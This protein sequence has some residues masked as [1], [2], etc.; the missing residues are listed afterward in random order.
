MPR[1]GKRR[2]GHMLTPRLATCQLQ[3]SI[4]R[5]SLECW[6][7]SWSKKPETASRVRGRIEAVLDF[8]AVRGYRVGQKSGPVEGASQRG[9]SGP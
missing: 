7:R 6:I 4:R 1:N 8:A 3:R 9:P 2:C 5:S